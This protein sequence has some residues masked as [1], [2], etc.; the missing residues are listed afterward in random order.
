MRALASRGFVRAGGLRTAPAPGV[1][2]LSSRSRVGGWRGWDSVR[3][4]GPTDTTGGNPS[5]Q[6]AGANPCVSD[7]STSSRLARTLRPGLAFLFTCIAFCFLVLPQL[8]QDGNSARKGAGQAFTTRAARVRGGFWAAGRA[9]ARE[10]GAQ[11][12]PDANPG[13]ARAA[14][15]VCGAFGELRLR[16]FS[17]LPETRSPSSAPSCPPHDFFFVVVKERDGLSF[18]STN[19]P[20]TVSSLRLGGK[21]ALHT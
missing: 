3:G 2:T 1:A 21:N 7:P 13:P 15:T 16:N 4:L 12:L 8:E 18:L 6:A 5:L 19:F 17:F 10:A 9:G 20:E 11:R 14:R